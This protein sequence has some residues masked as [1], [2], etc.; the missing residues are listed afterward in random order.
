M[1]LGRPTK[2]IALRKKQL[3]NCKA[4]DI[5]RIP[6]EGKYGE[7]KRKFS[8]GRIMAKLAQTSECVAGIVFIVMNLEKYLR[9]TF[10]AP[11][12]LATIAT[13][14]LLQYI[15]QQY[16]YKRTN[17]REVFTFNLSGNQ[18]R[19]LSLKSFI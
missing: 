19:I 1:P 18:I 6:I 11:F 14:R 7:A 9:D 16:T 2:D 3:K 4:D 15:R 12:F 17:L 8:L 13:K 10:F 5:A